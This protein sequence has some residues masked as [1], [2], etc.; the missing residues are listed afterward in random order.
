MYLIN[1]VI[2]LFDFR[3]SC[4]ERI[5]NHLALKYQERKKGVCIRLPLHELF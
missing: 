5:N 2:I 1:K 3:K 4:H